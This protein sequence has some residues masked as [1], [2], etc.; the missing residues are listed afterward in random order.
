MF[1]KIDYRENIRESDLEAITWMINSGC[2]P[3]VIYNVCRRILLLS[4]VTTHELMSMFGQ[5]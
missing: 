5:L 4:D 3:V 2:L 1:T